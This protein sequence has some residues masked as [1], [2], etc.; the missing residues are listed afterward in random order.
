MVG[1]EVGSAGSG[2]AAGRG[3][4]ACLAGGG[5]LDEVADDV[6]ERAGQFLDAEVD[7][8]HGS[9]LHQNEIS[10]MS[11]GY[12][13]ISGRVE[14]RQIPVD[15]ERP[16]VRCGEEVL[17]LRLRGRRALNRGLGNDESQ[18]P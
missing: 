14:E 13:E 9:V 6:D 11:I 12:H 17:D 5:G 15:A 4:E 1:R 2:F 16:P 8:G 18:A 7:R 3:S 10:S